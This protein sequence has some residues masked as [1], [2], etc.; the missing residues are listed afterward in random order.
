MEP[1]YKRILVKISGE[2][3]AGR[4]GRGLD[5]NV[6]DAI[7]AALRDCSDLGVQTAV[8]V[9]GG[10]IWRGVK[11]GGGCVE[12]TRADAMGMLATTINA[13]AVTSS[14]EKAGLRAK[15]MTAA[16]LGAAAD[17]YVR[18]RALELLEEGTIVVLGGGTGN[19]FFSTDTAAVLR[20]AELGADI[21]LMAKNV[22]AVYTSDPRVDPGAK[23]IELLTCSEIMQKQ[24]G[25]IDLTAAAMAASTNIP[26]MLFGVEDPQNIYRA[27]MGTNTGTLIKGQ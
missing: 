2:A 14:L 3:L 7:S 27:V 16:N 6:I 13:L 8:V 26:I 1:V 23:R 5:F 22:D 18:D 15:T 21:I 19:P 10:N 25:V 12:R 20:G 4:A 11:D 24:L 17:G 9:G